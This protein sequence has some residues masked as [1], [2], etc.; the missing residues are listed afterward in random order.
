MQNE[1]E[2]CLRCGWQIKL[3]MSADT[4]AFKRTER[5]GQ[6]LSQA[7][8]RKFTIESCNRY[9]LKSCVHEP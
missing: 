5:K 6:T 3:K 8:I 9:A 4:I 7:L 1:K 2:M